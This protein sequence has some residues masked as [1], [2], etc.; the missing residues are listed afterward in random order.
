MKIL[1]VTQY[2]WPENF[3]INL[4]AKGI[5]ENHDLTVLTGLPNYPEGEIYDGYKNKKVWIS[6]QDGIK[7]IRCRLI[8]RGKA[9]AF[10]LAL[11]YFSFGT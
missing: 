10:R 2:Y 11:N 3:K 4:V 5:S 1:L 6:E 9:N 8:S 7:V